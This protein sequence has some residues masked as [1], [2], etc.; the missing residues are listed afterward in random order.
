MIYITSLNSVG[1]HTVARL[2][3]CNIEEL[4]LALSTRK[5]EVHKEQI[6]KKLTLSQVG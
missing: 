6:V 1:V 4:K 2:M 3:G 5:M